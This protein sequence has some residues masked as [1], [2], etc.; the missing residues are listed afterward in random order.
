MKTQ[1]TFADIPLS[2]P[3]FIDV[4]WPHIS[5][6]KTVSN[7]AAFHIANE[8]GATIDDS[9]EFLAG[10]LGG[11]FA[12]SVIAILNHSTE[13]KICVEIAILDAID[14]WRSITTDKTIEDVYDIPNN[15]AALDGFVIAI[16]WDRW[17]IANKLKKSIS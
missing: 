14:Q 9:T 11:K 2:G 15:T 13:Q 8:T 17:E 12:D 6:S 1:I 4:M 16:G 3:S 5:D 7:F 10:P